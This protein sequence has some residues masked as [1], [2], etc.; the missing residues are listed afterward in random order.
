MKTKMSPAL[1]SSL[2][3]FKREIVRSLTEKRDSTSGRMRDMYALKLSKVR[4]MK[5]AA[6][7]HDYITRRSTEIVSAPLFELAR[8]LGDRMVR[9]RV[10]SW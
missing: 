9:V 4:S 2:L 5:L 7:K 8:I 3:W 10:Q 1:K 6:L